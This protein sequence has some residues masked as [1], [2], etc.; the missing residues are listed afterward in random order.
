MFRSV[1][2]RLASGKTLGSLLILGIVAGVS[3]LVVEYSTMASNV[4]KAIAIISFGGFCF[5]FLYWIKTFGGALLSHFRALN[6]EILGIK[7]IMNH[8]YSAIIKQ[9]SLA[10]KELIDSV[11]ALHED[12]GET[13]SS[14]QVPSDKSWFNRGSLYSLAAIPPARDSKPDSPRSI[15]RSAASM[16]TGADG[17][18]NLQQMLTAEESQWKRNIALIGGAGLKEYLSKSATI[19]E[20]KPYHTQTQI[21]EK[22]DAVVFE[23]AAFSEGLWAGAL[24][25]SR[26]NLMLEMHEAVL[27]LKKQGAIVIL[28]ELES[29]STFTGTLRNL[30]DFCI[31]ANHADLET[32]LGLVKQIQSFVDG[33]SSNV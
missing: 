2:T 12:S 24:N 11:Q 13:S 26:T 5:F 8:Q 6:A 33:K 18:A 15:G 3:S 23:E 28:I 32:G 21:T 14:S 17:R 7:R 19:T 22:F 4:L 20:L 25:A 10:E 16:T 29:T 1:L 27:K 30:S 31:G 9:I